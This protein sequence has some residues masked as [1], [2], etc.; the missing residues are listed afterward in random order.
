MSNVAFL[1]IDC[2]VE[3]ITYPA[4]KQTALQLYAA[5]T[6]NNHDKGLQ[7]GEPVM[8]ATSCLVDYPFEEGETA[9][10]NYSEN[11]GILDV[12]VNANIVSLTG[13]FAYSGYCEF[14]VVKLLV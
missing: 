4:N 5:D 10:K 11:E 9:I 3:K 7:P 2:E 13:K 12:L 6:S 8:T 1:G 14:P